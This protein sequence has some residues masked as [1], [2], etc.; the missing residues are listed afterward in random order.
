MM[1][2]FGVLGLGLVL[3]VIG[4][5]WLFLSIPRAAVAILHKSPEKR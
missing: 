4:G 5:A 1:G 3:G 2:F